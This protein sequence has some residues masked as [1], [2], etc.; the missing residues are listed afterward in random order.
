MLDRAASLRRWLVLTLLMVAVGALALRLPELDQ[1]PMHNDEAVNA[2][3]IQG[4]WERG[5]YRYNPDEYHGPALHYATLPF[6]WL[7]GDRDFDHLSERTLRWVVVAAGVALV[8]LV[9]LLRDALGTAATAFA[10]LLLALSPAMVFYSRYFIHEM[11]LVAFTLLFLASAWR[12]G[13]SRNPGWAALAGAGLG[14]MHATKE[15][16]VITLAAIV[17]AWAGPEGWKRWHSPRA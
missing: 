3:L 1:R 11:L 17:L 9:G 5:E 12:Y 16:F 13:Q 7:S 6:V 15:T 2:I 4:L 14:L 10:A 8:L